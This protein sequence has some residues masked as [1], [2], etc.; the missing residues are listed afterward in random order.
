MRIAG[1]SYTNSMA[2]QI[3]A[4]AGRQ[5]KLQNQATTGQSITAPEDDPAGMAQ[6]LGLQADRS[7]TAQYSQNIATLQNHSDL[8]A[9]ALQQLKT[10]SDRVSE[11]ATE[12]S[13]TL[14]TPAELQANAA[15]TT[16]I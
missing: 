1:T 12:S 5:Y 6:A 2:S 9:N 15:E 7:N 16:Q 11:L 14:S 3:N 8:I 10:I 4:L 13:D